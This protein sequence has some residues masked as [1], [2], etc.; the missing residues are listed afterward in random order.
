MI[1]LVI[2]ARQILL[3]EGIGD[4]MVCNDRLHGDLVKSLLVQMLHIVRKIQ[5]ILGESTTHIV[6]LVPTLF[7]QFLNFGTITS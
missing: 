1:V 2:D 4:L 7:Y 3:R 6:L 5:V